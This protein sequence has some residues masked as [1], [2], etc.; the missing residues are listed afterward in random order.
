MK[1]AVIFIQIFIAILLIILI[2]SQAKGAGLGSAWGGSSEFYTTR[3]G[4]EKIIFVATII[5]AT[6]FLLLSIVNLLLK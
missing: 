5:L 1:L 4:M 3:R 6:L 2:L